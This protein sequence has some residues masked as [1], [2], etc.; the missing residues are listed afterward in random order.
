MKDNEKFHMRRK[1]KEI[2]DPAV[3]EAILEKATVCRLG[4]VDRD[5][6]YIVPVNFGY[7]NNVLYFHSA[8]KGYKVELIK[9]NNKVCFEIETDVEIEKTDKTNCS[10]KYRSVIGRG[11]I[12]I[13]ENKEEKIHGLKSIMQQ[14]AAGEYSF[15]KDR[16]NTVLVARI[17]VDSLTGK[18]A[19]Y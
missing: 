3:I 13:I 19:G 7:E 12:Y 14:C 9:K 8:L 6:S 15:S 1:D 18:Q 4:L 16:L 5:E 2:A 10:V 17:D 11:R